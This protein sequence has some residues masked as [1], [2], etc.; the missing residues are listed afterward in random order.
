MLMFAADVRADKHTY[1]C[2]LLENKDK[3]GGICQMANYI[4]KTSEE[5][6]HERV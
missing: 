2:T 6:F 4:L 1:T 3:G 5:L